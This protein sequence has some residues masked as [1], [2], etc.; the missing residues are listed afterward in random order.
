MPRGAPRRGGPGP[1]P[2]PADLPHPALGRRGAG[3][4]A[5]RVPPRQASPGAAPAARPL[6]PGCRRSEPLGRAVGP[7]RAGPGGDGMRV[8]GRTR[9]DRALLA[10]KG[11]TPRQRWRARGRGTG[12]PSAGPRAEPRSLL[13]RLAAGSHCPL[14]AV[15]KSA[16]SSVFPASAF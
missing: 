2:E 15:R 3:T 11:R 8:P 7:G 6:F 4:R 14:L 12:A 9:R 5:P 13:D 10:G 16:L 1:G